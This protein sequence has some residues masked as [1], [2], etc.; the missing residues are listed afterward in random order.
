MVF[1]AGILGLA[2]LAAPAAERTSPYGK[3][4]VKLVSTEWLADH[5]KDPNLLIVDTQG[6][7]YDYFAE[8]IPGAVYFNDQA[9]RAPQQGMPVRY[10]APEAME[11]LFCR[12]GLNNDVPVVVYTGKGKLT[13]SG[14]GLGQ[15]MTAYTMTR[16]GQNRIYVLDGG[17]D[18]WTAEK[19]PVTQGFPRVKQGGFKA[20]VR[21]ECH[22]STEELKKLKDRADVILIDARPTKAYEGQAAWAR[23]GHIPGAVSLPWKATMS[24]DNPTLL[25]SDEEIAAIVKKLNVTPSKTIITYCGTG[26]EATNLFLLFRCYLGYPSVR[27]YEGSFTEWVADPDNP[28]VTGPNPR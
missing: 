28:T 13:G 20:A 15:T 7:V 2:C 1:G 14:D 11:A 8:H 16:F 19:R 26:R 23:P 21:N 9:L 17:L 12:L 22:V 10:L 6:D 25:K 24:P 3:G 27:L 5:L 18:K 4:V